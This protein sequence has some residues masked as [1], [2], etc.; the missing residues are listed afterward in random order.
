M[1]LGFLENT[2]SV[3]GEHLHMLSVSSQG[4]RTHSWI[5]SNQKKVPGN[6]K[7]TVLDTK[8]SRKKCS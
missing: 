1:I 3:N 8:F 7:Y 2:G 5:Q 6:V 4:M